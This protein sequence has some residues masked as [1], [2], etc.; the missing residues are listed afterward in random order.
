MSGLDVKVLGEQLKLA[1]QLEREKKKAEKKT[2]FVNKITAANPGSNASVAH[3]G[4]N[5]LAHAQTRYLDPKSNLNTKDCALPVFVGIARHALPTDLP[6]DP[7]VFEAIA[8][9]WCYLHPSDCIPILA[10]LFEKK[11]DLDLKFFDGMTALLPSKSSAHPELPIRPTRKQT[12]VCDRSRATGRASPRRRCLRSF[13][14]RISRPK[15][16]RIHR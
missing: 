5:A 4:K 11:F 6:R 12:S 3:P 2:K 13:T 9:K 1:L 16:Q 15:H 14:K 7:S 8:K 10:C